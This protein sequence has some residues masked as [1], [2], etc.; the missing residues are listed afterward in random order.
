[1]NPRFRENYLYSMAVLF[2]EHSINTS[3][4]GF[5]VHSQTMA[6]TKLPPLKAWK[7]MTRRRKR[8]LVLHSNGYPDN[9]RNALTSLTSDDGLKRMA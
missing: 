8:R 6:Q 7:S 1:M 5:S 2:L 3:N 4:K 9:T